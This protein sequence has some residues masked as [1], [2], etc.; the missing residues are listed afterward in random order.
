MSD[1][2]TNDY[3]QGGS[4]GREMAKLQKRSRTN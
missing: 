2:K 3:Y 4:L 1:S